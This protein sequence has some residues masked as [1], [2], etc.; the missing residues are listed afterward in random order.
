MQSSKAQ[1]SCKP[2]VWS[3]EQLVVSRKTE[4]EKANCTS[5]HILFKRGCQLKA[6]EFFIQILYMVHVGSAL[7]QANGT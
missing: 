1:K 4:K 6:A 7:V 3:K 2:V 5:A